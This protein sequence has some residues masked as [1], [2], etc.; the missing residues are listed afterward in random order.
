MDGYKVKIKNTIFITKYS[1]GKLIYTRVLEIS[2]HGLLYRLQAFNFN[3]T[4][5]M[6]Y[7]PN[8]ILI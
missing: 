7:Y 8:F 1:V 4:V 6:F 2:R 3:M 5:A